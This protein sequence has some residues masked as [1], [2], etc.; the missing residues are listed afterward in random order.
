MRRDE[1][2][3]DELVDRIREALAPGTSRRAS[4]VLRRKEALNAIPHGMAYT[5]DYPGLLADIAEVLYEEATATERGA[6]RLFEGAYASVA[7]QYECVDALEDIDASVLRDVTPPAS[8]YER[9]LAGI[10]R[11][12]Q[13]E[14]VIDATP[15]ARNAIHGIRESPAPMPVALSEALDAFLFAAPAALLR[16]HTDALVA[17][18][19]AVIDRVLDP[20]RDAIAPADAQAAAVLLTTPDLDPPSQARIIAASQALVGADTPVVRCWG[21]YVQTHRPASQAPTDA[22]AAALVDAV[23]EHVAAVAAEYGDGGNTA[24]WMLGR[25]AV[26]TATPAVRRRYVGT[27]GSFLT[28]MDRSIDGTVFGALQRVV[29]AQTLDEGTVESL[30]DGVLAGLLETVESSRRPAVRF[31][32]VLADCDCLPAWF[33]DDLLASLA[34]SLENGD[35]Q[36]V[37]A[38]LGA[39]KR[40]FEDDFETGDPVCP[41]ASERASPA[42]AWRL[43]DATRGALQDAPERRAHEIGRALRELLTASLLPAETVD[44]VVT[45]LVETALNG[46]DDDRG[47]AAIAVRQ[48]APSNVLA[49]ADARRLVADVTPTELAASSALLQTTTALLEHH[50]IG[51][52]FDYAA[53]AAALRDRVPTASVE[54]LP[55]IVH[56]LATVLDAHEFTRRADAFACLV[57]VV[58][59]TGRCAHQNHALSPVSDY[60]RDAIDATPRPTHPSDLDPLRDRLRAEDPH[61]RTAAVKAIRDG[62]STT[63]RQFLVFKEPQS[64]RPWLTEAATPDL[65]EPMLEHAT[66]EMG[67]GGFADPTLSVLSTF[68]DRGWLNNDTIDDVATTALTILKNDPKNAGTLLSVP[69]VAN[70][71]SAADAHHVL[72]TYAT[73]LR[74]AADEDP[75]IVSKATQVPD[76]TLE[77]IETLLDTGAVSPDAVL[78]AVPVASFGVPDAPS[79][80]A[81]LGRGSPDGVRLLSLLGTAAAATDRSLDSLAIT[82]AR[83]LA[84]KNFDD[85]TRLELVDELTALDGHARTRRE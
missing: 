7:V 48:L 41:A 51:A 77:V 84:T 26:V 79:F 2:D 65:L 52:F 66:G 76:G 1:R 75:I 3:P 8:E 73:S 25:G 64:K 15:D 49:K 42:V 27:L 81:Y 53:L 38:A 20:P 6:V 16:E 19:R 60:L 63:R 59:A 34:S 50:D 62:T 61:V 39:V 35:R 40:L 69:A 72:E 21:R 31:V 32:Q 47:P 68:L 28:D 54:D 22:R 23:S 4:T 56:A 78:E 33:V 18:R 70:R 5:T 80:D 45:S 67:D 36:A 11:L 14:A 44:M 30:F 9:L 24:I 13:L 58:D 57:A 85:T 37:D 46:S 55:V 29:T 82:I 12:L 74:D 43:V 71:L 17:T 83:A 10:L